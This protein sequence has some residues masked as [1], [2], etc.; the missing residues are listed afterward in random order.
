MPPVLSAITFLKTRDLE[1]TTAFYTGVMG[2]ALALDQGGCRIFTIRPGAHLGFCRTDGSTGS[3]EVILTLEVADVQAVTAALE[4]AGVPVEV[5]PRFNPQYNITQAFL[6]D[7]NGYL[8]EIQ[9]FLD[10]AWKNNQ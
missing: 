4:A 3:P 6:R 5:Q 7:P 10:P 2:F 8:I 1:Q 9:H